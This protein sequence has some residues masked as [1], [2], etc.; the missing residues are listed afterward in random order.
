MEETP[1]QPEIEKASIPQEPTERSVQ[2]Q[3]DQILAKYGKLLNNALDLIFVLAATGT[4]LSLYMNGLVVGK[5][6]TGFTIAIWIPTL[7]QMG[8]FIK[9]RRT[10]VYLSGLALLALCAFLYMAA[11]TTWGT[12]VSQI[13]QAWTYDMV[14]IAPNDLKAINMRLTQCAGYEEAKGFQMIVTCENK[15]CI[16][17]N[18]TNNMSTFPW[19]QNEV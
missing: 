2:K 12:H 8:L 19:E 3:A 17:E 18:I 16:S 10:D 7:L 11:D 1:K 15:T 5:A 14:Q 6:L 4:A 13:G 9:E